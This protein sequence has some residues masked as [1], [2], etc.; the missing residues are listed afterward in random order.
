ML[1]GFH[2]VGLH[3]HPIATVIERVAAA[4]YAAI[5]LNAETLPWAGPHV[6]PEIDAATRRDIRER[7]RAAGLRISAIGAHVPMV[8]ADAARRRAAIG[9]VNGCTDLARDVGAPVVHI[10]S[11]ERPD[12]VDA[13][14]AFGWFADAVT[15]TVEHARGQGIALAIEAIAGH[16]F[17]AIDDFDALARALPG[18]DFKI[19]L[20]PS[21]LVVQGLDPL[22]LVGEHGG[23]IV[24]VHAKDGAGR[25][26]DFTFPPL[27]EGEI[28]FGA[29]VGALGSVGYDGVVSVEYEAQV[30]GWQEDDATILAHGRRFLRALGI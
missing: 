20:D 18:V 4:G 7:A 15:L 23:R 28:D 6:G 11:G 16:A 12:G 17:H 1:S 8:E 14:R 10:L 5:E 2:S 13:A 24:H 25:F 22:R 21:H 29:L 27:G 26:P 30:C 3:R 19:N 9:W